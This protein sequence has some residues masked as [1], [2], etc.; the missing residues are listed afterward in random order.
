MLFFVLWVCF[1]FSARISLCGLFHFLSWR[2]WISTFI[3][4]Q[5]SKSTDCAIFCSFTTSINQSID[6][7]IREVAVELML[8]PSP[9][10]AGGS[11]P[12][13]EK[14]LKSHQNLAASRATETPRKEAMAS[15]AASAPRIAFRL[16]PMPTISDILRIYRLRAMK[17]LSQNFLLDQKITRKIVTMA[18]SMEDCC[19]MEV[20][21]GPG[22]LTRA[23]MAAGIRELTVIERDTRFIPVLQ[24]LRDCCPTVPMHVVQGDILRHEL[25]SLFPEDTVRP[26][27]GDELPPLHAIANLPFNISTPLTV[28]WLADMSTRSGMFRYGRVRMTLMYQH[29]VAQRMIAAAGNEQ[30]CRL[31]VM[32]QNYCSVNYLYTIRGEWEFHV[33]VFWL[34]GQSVGDSDRNLTVR[35]IDWL[36]DCMI[37][38][39]MGRLIGRSIDWLI[40][41]RQFDWLIDWWNVWLIDWFT[42]VWS[43]D[44]L[45]DWS[46]VWLI[47]WLIDWLQFDCFSFFSFGS[48]SQARYSCRNRRLMRVWCSWSLSQSR[49]L[50]SRLGWWRRWCEIFS[51]HEERSCT[52]A[53]SKRCLCTVRHY[54]RI[55]EGIS[56]YMTIHRSHQ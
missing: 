55:S 23:V 16:P 41:L 17:K 12:D 38:R 8:I 10:L 4:N 14:Q 48:C 56:R 1:S 45:I 50:N 18:G 6:R 15:A 44:W 32:C 31:S 28:R 3:L 39:L 25:Q 9:S 47:D 2:D 40:D 13:A 26:W 27:T 34:T 46:T 33:D 54:E 20:G 36:I 30:R 53:W 24:E 49:V 22:C 35:L 7:S 19:V 11:V 42:T 21:P 29:E 52:L 51:T 5:R 37:D 43:I